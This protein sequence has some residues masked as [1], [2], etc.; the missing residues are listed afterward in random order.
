ME[1][2]RPDTG[3]TSAFDLVREINDAVERQDLT[4]IARRMHPEVVWSHNIGVGTPEE[5][6]YQGRDRV[7][8]LFERILEPWEYLRATPYE[9]RDVGGGVFI[10]RGE[11]KAKH[12]AVATEI[13]TPYEQRLEIQDGL[14]VR[15]AMVQGPTSHSPRDDGLGR[16]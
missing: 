6:E 4:A 15:G 7:V 2:A 5:G 1:E 13:L 10:V 8:G 12:K 14:L 9:V 3:A 11:L 16:R